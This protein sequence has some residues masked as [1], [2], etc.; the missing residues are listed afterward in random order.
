MICDLC[1]HIVLRSSVNSLPT[2]GNSNKENSEVVANGELH[3]VVGS[4]VHIVLTSAIVVWCA[5]E[6]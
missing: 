1:L 2:Y 4:G 5:S 3:S 6:Q